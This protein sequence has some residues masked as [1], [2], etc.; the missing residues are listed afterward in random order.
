GPAL[1]KIPKDLRVTSIFLGEFKL[2]ADRETGRLY[3]GG[4]AVSVPL[5]IRA[6][7]HSDESRCTTRTVV[8][9]EDVRVKNARTGETLEGVR[10]EAV[11]VLDRRTSENVPGLIEGI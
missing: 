1:I 5:S 2:Y 8:L 11:Y 7:V 10:P 3:P 4:Q 9:E 6:D